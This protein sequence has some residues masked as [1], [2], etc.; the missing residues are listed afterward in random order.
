MT[1]IRIARA[2][3]LAALLLPG[4]ATAAGL[5][6]TGITQCSDDDENSLTCPQEPNFPRQDADTGRDAQTDL[7]KAGG[8]S[9]GFDFTRVCNSG[10]PAGQGSCPLDP[11]LGSNLNDW[12]CTRDNVTGLIWEIKTDDG[13]LRDKDW[14]YTWYNPDPYTNGSTDTTANDGAGSQG[15]STSC[16]SILLPSLC[17]TEAYVAAVNNT[18]TTPLCGYTDW[19][20]PTVDELSSIVDYS[21]YDPTIDAAYFPETLCYGVNNNCAAYWSA[22]PS[23]LDP[24]DAW[25]VWFGGGG[26][27]PTGK[28]TLSAIRLVRG[29]QWPATAPQGDTDPNS[30]PNVPATTP[31]DDFVLDNVY[32]TAYHK[33]T[34][35]TWKRC[36]EGLVWSGTTCIDD[37]NVADLYTWSQALQRGPGIGTFAGF[38]DWRLPNQKELASIVERRNRNPAINATVYPNTP[39]AYFWSA[40]PWAGRPDFAWL[41]YFDYG[42]DFPYVKDYPYFAVRLVRGGQYSLLSVDKGGTGSGTV[43]S[44]LPGIDCGKFCKGSF[45]NEMF[46]KGQIILTASPDDGSVFDGWTDCPIPGS[47]DKANECTVTLQTAKDTNV[48]ANF[49]PEITV[50]TVA[51]DIKPGSFPNSINP[52][53][54]GVIPVAILTTSVFDATT[55]NPLSV[56]FGPDGATES[57][58]RGHIEDVDGDGDQDLVLHFRTQDTGIQCGNTSASL[59]GKTTSGIAIEGFDSIITVGCK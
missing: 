11:P 3:L 19:R 48:A 52:R 26:A 41:V 24:D 1:R 38:S 45:A 30:N 12:G 55:V 25:W 13:G 56:K 42:Y 10:E 6:D 17:N 49:S 57:H 59:T 7:S 8:G 35:L 2:S 20:M 5:N 21:K 28:D 31:T 54:K 37:P 27:G 40:S 14:L 22:S 23:A 4:L 32:G 9:A 39:T 53:S 34:G 18:L 33:K 36:Y 15:D 44:N 47:G 58:G 29:G 50:I 43:T 46:T 16:N 51:I